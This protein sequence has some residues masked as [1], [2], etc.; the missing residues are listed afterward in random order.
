MFSLIKSYFS[1][2][3]LL[4][5]VKNGSSVAYTKLVDLHH[6]HLVDYTQNFIKSDELSEQIVK[7]ALV[8]VWRERAAID[9]GISAKDYLQAIIWEHIIGFLVKAATNTRLKKQIWYSIRT[10]GNKALAEE[11]LKREQEFVF[12]GIGN[13]SLQQKLQSYKLNSIPRS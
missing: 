8:R 6:D 2:K 3:N 9:T 10:T 7:E 13:H 12:Y 1:K 5:E 11:V 4:K